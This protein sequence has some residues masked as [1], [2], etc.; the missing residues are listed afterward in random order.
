[1]EYESVFNNY[2][3][4]QHAWLRSWSRYGAHAAAVACSKQ[5]LVT[6]FKNA[7]ATADFFIIGNRPRVYKF[8]KNSVVYTFE[9]TRGAAILISVY[10]RTGSKRRRKYHG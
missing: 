3:I 7:M 9:A 4:T 2:I 8:I 5:A 1:M 6:Q 10:F